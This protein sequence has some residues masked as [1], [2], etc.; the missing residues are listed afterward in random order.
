MN[1]TYGSVDEDDE[2]DSDS[3]YNMVDPALLDLDMPVQDNVD[4]SIGPALATLEDISISREEFYTLCS[5][6][7]EGQQHLF[8]FIMKHVQ[9]LMLN[10]EIIFPIQIHSI[11]F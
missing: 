5:Q 9:Q 1:I 4:S 6:L 8:N 2:E 7:N 10:E 3:E 11:F